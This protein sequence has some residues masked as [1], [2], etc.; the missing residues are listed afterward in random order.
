MGKPQELIFSWCDPARASLPAPHFTGTQRKCLLQFFIKKLRHWHQN[1]IKINSSLKLA[2]TCEWSWKLPLKTS[3]FEYW[4][5]HYIYQIWSLYFLLCFLSVDDLLKEAKIGPNGT[6]KYEEFAH[7]ICIPTVD[8]WNSGDLIRAGPETFFIFSSLLL[9]LRNQHLPLRIPIL[10]CDCTCTGS[11]PISREALQRSVSW[12]LN[13]LDVTF[14]CVK[15]VV[16]K[17]T[18]L[19]STSALTSRVCHTA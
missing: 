9:G 8:Y 3:Y 15:R 7:A 17:K 2:G 5:I 14:P 16:L 18:T 13:K 10:P 1:Q 11:H 4:N 19:T 6:I 12:Y